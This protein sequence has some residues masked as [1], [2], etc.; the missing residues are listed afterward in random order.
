VK[1]HFEAVLTTRTT[2][3][4]VAPKVVFVPSMVFTL[5]SRGEAPAKDEIKNKEQSKF[6]LDLTIIL[7]SPHSPLRQEIKLSS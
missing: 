5:T 3:G 7:E 6:N 1:P 4:L 2:L